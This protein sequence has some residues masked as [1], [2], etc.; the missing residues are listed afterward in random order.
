M[1]RR[2]F[3]KQCIALYAN[4]SLVGVSDDPKYSVVYAMP[5]SE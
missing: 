3:L 1:K 5:C 4:D 2:I